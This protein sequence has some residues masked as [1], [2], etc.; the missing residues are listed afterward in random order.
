[1]ELVAL[2]HLK[3]PYRFINKINGSQVSDHCLLGYLFVSVREKLWLHWQLFSLLWLYLANS[4]VSVYRTIS[5]L[6]LKVPRLCSP[7]P[8]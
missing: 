2:E 6:V 7:L 3:S 5:P 8:L 1:M 4:Q